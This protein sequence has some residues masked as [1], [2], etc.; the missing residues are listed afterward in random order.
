MKFKYFKKGRTDCGY[1]GNGIILDERIFSISIKNKK[2]V[3]R[4]ECDG[5]F[6]ISYTPDA[7]VEVLKEAIAYIE[8]DSRTVMTV[9]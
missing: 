8:N 5:F 7:A 3:F 2:V 6:K 9:S 4:E 1:G